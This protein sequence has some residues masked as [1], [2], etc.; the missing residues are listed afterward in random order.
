MNKKFFSTFLVIAFSFVCN[1][2]LE[3]IRIVFKNG[4]TLNG[5]G[6]VKSKTI[7]YKKENNADTKEFNFSE[8]KYIETKSIKD[9]VSVKTCF[10]KKRY[11]ETYVGVQEEYIGKKVELYKTN[12]KNGIS[13]M[14]T[15]GGSGGLGLGMLFNPTVESYYLKKTKEDTVLL[16]DSL[17]SNLEYVLLIY[18][19][20]CPLV[21]NKIKNKELNVKENLIDII[22]LYET[23]C[24]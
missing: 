14:P 9:T 2:Q 8:I 5:I 22:K 18:F 6:K 10:F 13:F 23:S 3:R 1:A 24:E 20:K 17:E 12:P 21:V 15:I 7:K 11:E 19:E 4:D 16:L